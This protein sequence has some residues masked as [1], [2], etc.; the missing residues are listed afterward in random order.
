MNTEVIGATLETARQRL[1]EKQSNFLGL[2]AKTGQR[3]SLDRWLKDEGRVAIEEAVAFAAVH[4]DMEEP[5]IMRT[6][7]SSLRFR[8]LAGI[9]TQPIEFADP[10][11]QHG[12]CAQ[13]DWWPERGTWDCKLPNA[14][15]QGKADAWHNHHGHSPACPFWEMTES[16]EPKG[17]QTELDKMLEEGEDLFDAQRELRNYQKRGI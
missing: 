17:S 15:K 9:L 2:M 6:I 12:F 5:G 14:I 10:T 3:S 4:H 7:E 13:M 1:L 11:G 16:T 8:V